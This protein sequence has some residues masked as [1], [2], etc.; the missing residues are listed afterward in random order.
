MSDRQTMRINADDLFDPKVEGFLEEQAMLNTYA[1]GISGPEHPYMS[2]EIL[3]ESRSQPTYEQLPHFKTS[4]DPKRPTRNG[5]WEYHRDQAERS[6]KKQ[7]K[8]DKKK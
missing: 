1:A 3:D 7:L 6:L 2:D 4:Y 8:K 5:F